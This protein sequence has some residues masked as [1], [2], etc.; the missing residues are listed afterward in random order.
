[1]YIF[2]VFYNHYK[3]INEKRPLNHDAKVTNWRYPCPYMHMQPRQLPVPTTKARRVC[4]H[5]A[6]VKTWRYVLAYVCVH[7]CMCRRSWRALAGLHNICRA[8]S[9]TAPD[10]IEDS[11]ALTLTLTQVHLH[12]VE[13]RSIPP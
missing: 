5:V 13:P 6:K 2:V 10:F 8:A 3:N 9:C 12:H 7:V 4:N 1:M 11:I